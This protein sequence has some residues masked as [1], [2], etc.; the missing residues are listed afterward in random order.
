[1]CYR[2]EWLTL[3][4]LL[5]VVS[6]LRGENVTIPGEAA[7]PYPT[8]VNLSI[9]WKI[10][11]DDNHNGQVAVRYRKEAEDD[12]HEALPLRR[13]P[14][15]RSRGTKPIFSWEN[16]HSGSIF[17]L[18]PDTAYE[19][20][21]KLIDPDGGSAEKTVRARTRPVPRASAAA[22]VK[23]V[24]PSQFQQAAKAANPGDILVLAPGNYGRFDASRDG[25]AGKPI[26]FRSA[27]EGKAV[28][29]GIFLRERKHVYLEGLACKRERID[30]LGAEHCVVR[31]CSVEAPNGIWAMRPPG[32]RNCY[33]ADNSV[34]GDMS[35]TVAA[36]GS[37]G[38]NHGE[39]IRCTGPGN[40]ICF[41]RVAGFRDCISLAED[42]DVHEQFSIDIYNNDVLIGADDGIEADFAMHNCRVLRNRLTNC[43]VGVSS[44]PGLGGPNYF[45]RNV[46]YNILH[47]PLKLQRFSAGDV[48]LHNTVVKIGDGV[49]LFDPVAHTLFRNNIFIGGQGGGSV[50]NAPV[51]SGWAADLRSPDATCNFDY[52]GFG[53]H[54]TAFSVKIAGRNYGSVPE[55]R[56]VTTEKHAVRLDLSIFDEVPL[57]QPPFPER[58]PLDLRLKPGSAAVDAGVV[59]PNVN[60][61]YRGKAPDLGA[62]ELS[63]E[64]PIYGPRPPGVDEETSAAKARMKK[65]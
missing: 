13:V 46:M 51:G 17:D 5:V 21:L 55:L 31:R 65:R 45:I 26:V 60:D 14:A 52:D 32:A 19:I 61:G 44:Q 63:Q 24:D 47:T 62:Y 8:V 53:T 49:I 28:F 4:W 36:M 59:L 18:A 16:K 33:I 42:E 22:V 20:G 15:G 30:L 39:G 27:A 11:G 23:Q 57:P 64:L 48:C 38:K 1:M 10:Q 50:N 35:W 41:N 58:K 29:Q 12:W 2:C 54:G 7:T 37:S 9:E 34:T 3:S 43:F 40:V 6:L 56:A 25:S